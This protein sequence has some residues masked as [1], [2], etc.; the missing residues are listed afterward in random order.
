MMRS[1]AAVLLAIVATAFAPTGLA[2]Q[3]V[4]VSIKTWKLPP[5]SHYPHDPMVAADG[6]I[7]YSGER[8]NI[9]GRFDPETERFTEFVTDFPYSEPHGLKEGTDGSVWFT[10]SGAEPPYIG[11]LNPTTGEFTE[12]PVTY[13]TSRDMTDFPNMRTYLPL[14]ESP[15]G[16]HSL[17]IDQRGNGVVQHVWRKHARPTGARHRQ[18]Y[19]G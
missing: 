8:S 10:A 18:G 11:K 1:F 13:P 19:G 9:L 4:E 6:S 16:V 7:W 17:A 2:A 15:R 3:E 12:Y 5:A 14:D